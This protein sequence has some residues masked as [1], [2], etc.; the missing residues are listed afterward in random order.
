MKTRNNP[1]RA[2][3]FRAVGFSVSVIP[4]LISILSYFPLWVEREDESILSGL[5]VL[6]LAAA[7]IPLG[8]YVKK[9]MRSPSVPIMWLILFATFFALSKIAAEMTVISFVGF[10]ANL[11]GSI[12]FKLASRYDKRRSDDEKRT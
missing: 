10:T 7:L 2:L 3:F 12:F 1:A 9:E 8:K 6:L 4:V 5:S 11:I